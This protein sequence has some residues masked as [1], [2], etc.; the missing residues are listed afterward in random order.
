M[1]HCPACGTELARAAEPGEAA[2][3]ECPRCSG[4]LQPIRLG[5][6]RLRECVDCGGL[7]IDNRTFLAICHDRERLEPLLAER[8][9]PATAD[10][11]PTLRV[12]YI[13]CPQCQALMSRVNFARV[14]GV[15]VDVCR[16]HGT[17]F[18]PGELRRVVEFIERGG[19]PRGVTQAAMDAFDLLLR[20]GPA[21][22]AVDPW[23]SIF[24]HFTPQ[25][26]S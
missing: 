7:W 24:G 10:A 1:R 6:N 15:V 22:A 11:A 21:A 16:E 19:I 9:R 2:E 4:A 3:M 23:S 13:R 17:W 5:A 12:G 20:G 25:G 26:G 14:S 18:E 8:P